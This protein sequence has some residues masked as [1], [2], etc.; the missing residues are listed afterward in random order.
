MSTNN[1]PSAAVGTQ[2]VTLGDLASILKNLT[3]AITKQGNGGKPKEID[4]PKLEEV[5]GVAY[6]TFR[7]QFKKCNELNQWTA[8]RAVLRLQ[9]C[10]S[11]QAARAVEHIKFPAACSL[12][13]AFKLYDAIFISAASQ[14]L[15][16]AQFQTAERNTGE[17]LLLWHTR[18]REL[19]IRGYPSVAEADRETHFDLKERFTMGLR[20][21]QLSRALRSEVTWDTATYTDLLRRA[22]QITASDVMVKQHYDHGRKAIGSIDVDSAFIPSEDAGV[23]AFSAPNSARGRGQ[24]RGRSRG[25]GRGRGRGTS[26]NQCWHCGRDG[27]F[28]NECLELQRAR[29]RLV[30]NTRASG[31]NYFRGRGVSRG[32]GPLRRPQQ[33]TPQASRPTWTSGPSLNALEQEHYQ[34]HPDQPE[35]ASDTASAPFTYDYPLPSEGN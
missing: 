28:I 11:G 34:D 6:T 32:R 3:G 29:S 4:P 27:H 26:G 1:D 21:V 9:T 15:H 5:D 20:N 22:T 12:E 25:R 17:T 23:A 33:G 30:H 24:S 35:Q 10:L 14:A 8:D 2:N 18:L 16:K 31:M 7:S 13:A 19:F